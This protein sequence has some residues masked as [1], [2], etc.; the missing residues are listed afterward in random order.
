MSIY[1]VQNYYF[2]NTLIKVSRGKEIFPIIL[3]FFFPSACCANNFF[4][5]VTSPPYLKEEKEKL[6]TLL[7]RIDKVY[8]LLIYIYLLI[9]LLHPFCMVLKFLLQLLYSL[10]LLGLL[11]RKAVEEW[12]RE[13]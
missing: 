2:F 9:L 4:L 12:F 7:S 1:Y 8:L 10:S 3:I 13:A 5:L 11:F 6:M